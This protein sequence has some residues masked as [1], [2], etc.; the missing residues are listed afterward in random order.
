[1]RRKRSLPGANSFLM[2]FTQN[3]DFIFDKFLLY[4]NNKF[5]C[6]KY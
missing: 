4:I 2:V 3:E 1:M 5:K 6:E